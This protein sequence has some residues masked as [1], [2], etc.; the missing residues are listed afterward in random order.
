MSH[1]G[2]AFDLLRLMAALLVVFGHSW[3]LTGHEDLLTFLGGINAGDLG[4]GVFFLLS[5]YLVSAS[6]LADPSLK[7][8]AARRALRIYPAYA[9]V[10]AVLALVV[11]PLVTRLAP[12]AYLT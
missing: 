8:F 3:V 1:R 5:G 11:G 4:V 2:N 6:W 12:A 7:R 10:V 9:L